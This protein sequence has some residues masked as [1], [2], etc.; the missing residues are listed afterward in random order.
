MQ[1]G[2]PDPGRR[3]HVLYLQPSVR[4]ACPGNEHHLP[5]PRPHTAGNQAN[6]TTAC[7][8]IF[9]TESLIR[10]ALPVLLA[11]ASDSLTPQRPDKKFGSLA[12]QGTSELIS[13]Q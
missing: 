11:S 9:F 7:L 12:L 8:N 4:P 5:R 1:Q 3:T 10:L 6:R 13:E 2:R